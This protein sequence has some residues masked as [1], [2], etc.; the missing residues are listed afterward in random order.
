MRTC[1][2][3]FMI[4]I[5]LYTSGQFKNDNVLYHTIFP[6]DLCKELSSKPDH[7]LLD[8]RSPGEFGDSSMSTG[9]NL[10]HLKGAKN[11]DIRQLPGRLIEIAAYRNKP[12]FVYC[13]H[14][15]RSRRVSKMLSDSGFTQVNNINGGITSIYLLDEKQR[16]CLSS[17]IQTSN[18]Y[19]VISPA[20]LCK[21]ISGRDNIYLLDVRS[22]SAWKHISLNAKSNAYGSF[23]GTHH[24]P[25]DSLRM[26][27]NEIPRDKSIIITDLY[28]SDASVA[29]KQLTDLGY[30]NVSF[31]L[32]GFD[33][34]FQWDQEDQ[35]CSKENYLPAAHYT[36]INAHAFPRYY[37]KDDNSLLLDIR[38]PEEFSNTHQQ[39]FR[40][41]GHL[42]NAT[43]IPL[44]DLEINLKKIESY[45]DKPVI[46]YEFGGGSDSYEAAE[47]L[48]KK[49]FKY[50]YV[51][52]GGIFNVR[53]TASNVEGQSFMHDWVVDVPLENQ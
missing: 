8:V 37:P 40:N 48:V 52:A 33:R 3:F 41:I 9:L 32:E 31:L 16:A 24:I 51:L 46:V 30:H 39:S 13:S 49:G 4:Q 2:L 47:T 10:G 15:Q 35:K 27:I 22:D 38:S 11:I 18:K 6:Q 29:A 12:I 36:I 42:K 43:N 14:S 20:D 34:Y 21:K 50:V 1:F 45:K 7:L 5:S 23:K 25:L 44:K 53:W 19:S 26:M 28:G 17:M